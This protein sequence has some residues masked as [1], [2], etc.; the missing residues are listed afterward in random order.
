MFEYN[1]LFFKGDLDKAMVERVSDPERPVGSV[2]GAVG[3]V[4]LAL[5]VT[6]HPR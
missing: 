3:A 5:S 4:E 1:L 6:L 2:A